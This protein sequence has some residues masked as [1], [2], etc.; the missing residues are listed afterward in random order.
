M[1]AKVSVVA[2]SSPTYPKQTWQAAVQGVKGVK[3]AAPA[4]GNWNCQAGIVQVNDVA[5]CAPPVTPQKNDVA[6]DFFRFDSSI[7]YYAR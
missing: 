7:V 5:D 1:L 6:D 3:G 4:A 2:A